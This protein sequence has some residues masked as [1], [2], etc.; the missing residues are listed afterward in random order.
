MPKYIIPL[1]Y[2]L[3]HLTNKYLIAQPLHSKKITPLH[4]SAIYGHY[5]IAQ[6]LLD[7]KASL[8][9]ENDAG[10]NALELAIS[11]QNKTVVE[12]RKVT[13]VSVCVTVF[14]SFKHV[15]TTLL[16]LVNL[17]Y[18]SSSSIGQVDITLIFGLGHFG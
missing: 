5:K 10:M 8:A 16:I 2:L 17:N 15:D 6:L 11:H 18:P 9:L 4:L 13:I 3:N 7:H 1:L 12:V 14:R